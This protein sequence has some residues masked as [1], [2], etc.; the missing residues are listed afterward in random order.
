MCSQRL[1]PTYVLSDNVYSAAGSL[2][3]LAGLVDPIVSV[4]YTNPHI[5]GMGIDPFHFSL[6]HSSYAFTI[7]PVVDL[8]GCTT[9]ADV[10]HVHVEVEVQPTL[11]QVLE[12][13]NQ[14]MN[15]SFEDFLMCYDP[16]FQEVLRL[17]ETTR[18]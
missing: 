13:A 6:P 15:G 2:T 17:I 12:Y 11:D 9:A 8:T 14:S 4:G 5:L 3:T 10:F 1:T 18:P 16:V 7:E